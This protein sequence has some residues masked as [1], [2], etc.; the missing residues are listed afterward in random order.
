MAR[1]AKRKMQCSPPVVRKR[2]VRKRRPRSKPFPAYI[3]GI[4]LR[5][6]YYRCSTMTTATLKWSI[7]TARKNGPLDPIDIAQIEVFDD[8]GDGPKKIG[9]PTGA[10]SS[11]TTF[12][13]APL[14]PGSHSFTVVV[15]TTDGK[16]SEPSNV[17][18]V[19]VPSAEPQQEP[20]EEPAPPEPTQE[21]AEALAVTDLSA[22]L[23]T[24]G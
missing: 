9:A 11:F 16:R 7:P 24:S 19:D 2:I 1:K 15:V 3:R 8:T 10:A 23:N 17:V 18:T 12:K 4:D 21:P 6:H 13:D 14:T 5:I 20:A 22:T